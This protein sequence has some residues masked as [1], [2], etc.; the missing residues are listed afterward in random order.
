MQKRARILVRACV[1]KELDPRPGL[2]MITITPE[3]VRQLT[4][5]MAARKALAK[6]DGD[7]RELH[8][9]NNSSQWITHLFDTPYE[10]CHEKLR[11]Y[12]GQP[13]PLVVLPDD[14]EIPKDRIY[15]CT[16]SCIVVHSDTD[17]IQFECC[18]GEKGIRGITVLD[19]QPREYMNILVCGHR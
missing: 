12:P 3:D 9:E 16:K 6:Q 14:F 4:V 17:V 19:L 13:Y 18:T 7:I 1:N 2:A 8:F 11:L 10:H 5:R 15:Q